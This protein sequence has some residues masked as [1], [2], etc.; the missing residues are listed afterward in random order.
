MA[1][2]LKAGFGRVNVNP[3]MGIQISGY[4]MTRL[5]DGIL[6]DLEVNAL[7]LETA[8]GSAIFLSLDNCVPRED[9]LSLCRRSVSE[10]TG[11][12]YEAVFTAATHT[13]T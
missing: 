8:N 2:T 7:A 13:H 3:P 11:V 6:D 12:P 10:A 9:L 5:A 4:Y 1:N